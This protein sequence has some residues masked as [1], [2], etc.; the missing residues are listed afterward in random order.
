MSGRTKI[1]QL[2]ACKDVDRDKVDLGV[3][4]LASL[5][6]RHFDDL[7]GAI[8][9]DDETILP[10]SRALHRVSGG[11]AGIGALESVLMLSFIDGQPQF[12]GGNEN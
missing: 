3:T 8:F 1:F 12:T 10:Q 5:R 2:L 4:V 7:A 6:C 11:S 9:D